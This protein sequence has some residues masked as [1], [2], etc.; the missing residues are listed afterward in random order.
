MIDIDYNSGVV[1][2]LFFLVH[3]PPP[4]RSFMS[5]PPSL[6]ACACICDA[7]SHCARDKYME[8]VSSLTQ[9]AGID[10][11]RMGTFTGLNVCK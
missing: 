2:D 6:L 9:L 1:L 3:L 8:C 11:V 10:Q 5:V 7:I 4:D